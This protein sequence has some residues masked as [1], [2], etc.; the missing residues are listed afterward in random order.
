[1]LPACGRS[2]PVTHFR[3]HRLADPA[4]ADDDGGEGLLDVDR[5]ILQ[6]GSAGKREADASRPDHRVLQPNTESMTPY[7]VSMTRTQMR[8]MTMDFVVVWPSSMAPP[9]K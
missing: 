4:P 1:M 3:K 7:T 8:L 9:W 2:S 6:D 5:E